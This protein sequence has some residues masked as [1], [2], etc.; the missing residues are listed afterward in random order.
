M[1]QSAVRYDQ[2]VKQIEAGKLDLL[3]LITVSDTL[4]NEGQPDLAM[5]LYKLW[6]IANPGSPMRYAAAF[7]CGSMHVAQGDLTNGAEYLQLAIASNPEFAAARINLSMVQERQGNIEDSLKTSRDLI[8]RLSNINRQNIDS[9]ILALKN[10]ARIQRGTPDAENALRQAIEI[11]PAQ[12]EL[13]QHWINNRQSR[14]IWPLFETVGRLRMGDLKESM[15]PLTASMYADDPLLQLAVARNYV[16][17]VTRDEVFYTAGRWPTPKSAKRKKLKIGYLS[18]DLCNHAIGYL[19]TDLFGCHDRSRYEL[20]VYNIGER[21][22]D[23]IQVKIMGDVDHWCDIKALSDRD[24]AK[25]IICDG[26]DILLDI[27]G[28]TN[29]QRTR[30]LSMKPAPII[31]NWLGYP[32][33]IGSDFHDYIIADDFIIPE[34]HEIFYSEKVVRLPCYQP[35]GKLYPVPLPAKSKSDLGLPENGVVFCCFNG[36]VKI[37][38]PVFSRWMAI[39]R[40][41]PGSVLWLRGSV[42][43]TDERL[44]N[45]AKQR[46]VS[47]ERLV[48][49]PFTSNTEYLANHRYADIFLDTF[50]YGAHTTASDALRMG[51]PIITLA[52]LSFPSRVCGS[53]S[54]AAGITE[55]ICNTPEEYVEL[56]IRL[57]NNAQQRAELKQ[58]MSAQV[59]TGILFD[60]AKLVTHLEVILEQMWSDYCTDKMTR[61]NLQGL[62]IRKAIH[63]ADDRQ[64]AKCLSISGY[65][66]QR[67]GLQELTHLPS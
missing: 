42:G 34:T 63:T 56:A 23:P 15:A 26:I 48:F 24:A 38:E 21:N 50:P 55:L 53:L 28:H 39:L 14:C 66:Q 9:K 37:T 2:A 8:E 5:A 36:A 30:L 22:N 47:P 7:N 11:D 33:T 25:K 52:G 41:V 40:S 46:G 10:I 65:L 18:S 59:S 49:L 61:H 58:R 51:V 44:R 43:D 19:M 64:A 20:F 67:S 45:Q 35:N 62:D 1:E 31:V 3:A 4:N 32:G 16:N 54:R 57:G 13:V 29:Y 60:S 17:Q 27:N 6:L 12:T